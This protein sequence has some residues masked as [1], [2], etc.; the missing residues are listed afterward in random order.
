MIMA[1]R[2]TLARAA[3]LPTQHGEEPEIPL[4][5]RTLALQPE[6]R[7]EH[8]QIEELFALKETLRCS[9]TVVKF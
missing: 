8:R 4:S 5:K 1:G 7:A 6:P 9:T 2:R 3:A